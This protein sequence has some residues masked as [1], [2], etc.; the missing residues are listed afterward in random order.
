[1]VK[2]TL[3]LMIRNVINGKPYEIIEEAIY[4]SV[5]KKITQ[6]RSK[7]KYTN[8]KICSD[9]YGLLIFN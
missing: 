3:S 9:N 8:K 1:M 6:A 7:E 5:K 2:N 4:K